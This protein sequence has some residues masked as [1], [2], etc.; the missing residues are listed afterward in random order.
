MAKTGRPT[1]EER[2]ARA[3]KVASGEIQPEWDTDRNDS[4]TDE[5]AVALLERSGVALGVSGPNGEELDGSTLPDF[6]D[7]PVGTPA[8]SI[9]PQ[10]SASSD[11]AEIQI[12]AVGPEVTTALLEV[13]CMCLEK[14]DFI[15]LFRKLRQYSEIRLHE[16]D[17][18]RI[19]QFVASR[20]TRDNHNLLRHN[21]A[22]AAST[23]RTEGRGMDFGSFTPIHSPTL[24]SLLCQGIQPRQRNIT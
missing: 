11:V 13:L 3:A 10:E 9:A 1:N 14:Q 23:L 21:A 7:A 12:A 2:A 5:A 4:P 20:T 6:T 17:I 15:V 24:A 18:W 8:M 16:A 22:I 19:M